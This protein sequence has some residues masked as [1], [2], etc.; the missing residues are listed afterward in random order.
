MSFL[1]HL[2]VLRWHL[3]R[4]AIAIAIGFIGAFIFGNWIAENIV[5]AHKNP[6]FITYRFICKLSAQMAAWFP[7]ILSADT[8]CIGQNLPDRLQNFSMAG[9]FMSHILMALVVGIVVAF[10]YIVYEIWRFVKPA[11]QN[12]ER[13][14]AR[15]FVFYT[16]VLFLSGISFAYFLIAP[17]SVNFFLTYQLTDEIENIPTFS[18]YVSLVTTLVISCGLV[19]QL[20]IL[21]YFLSKM[22]IVTPRLLKSYRRHALVGTL[23]LSSVI[24]PPDVLSQLLVSVPLWILYEISI[25]ISGAVARKRE[26]N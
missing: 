20:P 13:R 5:L 22:G 26:M 3:I 14:M 6:D 11:L 4:S 2:E 23:V 16:T 25:V 12:T 19:F 7:G 8:V 24:T 17:L 21:I 10:P 18:S 9:Q 1:Q 15:G